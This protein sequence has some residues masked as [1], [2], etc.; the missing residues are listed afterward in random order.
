[1]ADALICIIAVNILKW[2][3]M[4]SL[5]VYVCLRAASR[6][7]R[8]WW[9]V[10][11]AVILAGVEVMHSRAQPLSLAVSLHHTGPGNKQLNIHFHTKAPSRMQHPITLTR[12]RFRGVSVVDSRI[13]V[14]PLVSQ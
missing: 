11:E 5:Q 13:Q 2:Y 9:P 7:P 3:E 6:D 10:D 4:L 12:I 14:R 8:G 1:M